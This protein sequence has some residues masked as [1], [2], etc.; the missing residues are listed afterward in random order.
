VQSSRPTKVNF[1]CK[2]TS[3]DVQIVKIGPSILIQLALLLSLE[4]SM[5]YGT[6]Q[7]ARHP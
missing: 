1:L 3:Y 6:F 4:N 5:L 7:S 2:N